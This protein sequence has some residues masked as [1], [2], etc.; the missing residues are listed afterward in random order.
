MHKEKHKFWTLSK[1]FSESTYQNHL[2]LDYCQQQHPAVNPQVFPWLLVCHHHG[3]W[4]EQLF[5]LLSWKIKLYNT[6]KEFYNFFSALELIEYYWNNSSCYYYELQEKRN[7][8]YWLL[9]AV[10]GTGFYC[11]T[12]NKDHE[13]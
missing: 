6:I 9:K 4:N 10:T 11:C 12:L 2:C 13:K 5:Y 1:I 7:L 3:L 8:S